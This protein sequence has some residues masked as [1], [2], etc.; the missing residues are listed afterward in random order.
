MVRWGALLLLIFAG[1]W[2]TLG[3]DLSDDGHNIALAWRMS[4]GD[5]PFADE[6]NLRATG[7]LLAV[8]FTWLWTHLF[9][10]TGLVLASRIFF[11]AVAFGV[12]F[13]AYRA[14]RTTLRPVSAA[15]A[16]TAPLMALPY[17]LGQISY[18]TMPVFGLVLGTAAGFAAVVRRDR[19][20]AFIS[21]VAVAVGV[22][23][24]PMIL[25]GGAILLMAVAISSRR[26]D[27]VGSL[28]L[29]SLA[30]LV[31]FGLWL[32]FGISPSLVGDTLRF[33]LDAQALVPPIEQRGS[34]V[35]EVY[36]F[37]L[38]LRKYWPMWGAA[39][40]AALPLLPDRIRAAAI[41]TVPVLAAVP[42]LH[43]MFNGLPGVAFGRLA[44]IY[45][46]VVSLAL[47][48]PVSV[49]AVQ[50]RRRD[51]VV[52]I[53]L[54]LPVA[55]VQVPLIAATT[56]SGP[57]W[58]VHV[59][60]VC[61]LL[62]A[63]AAG[64]CEMVA[65]LVPSTQPLIGVLL[66]VAIG[67]LL[68]FKPFK[69]PFPWLATTRISTGAF[70]GISTDAAG[71]ARINETSAAA[72]RWVEPGEGVLL[73]GLAGDYLLTRGDPVTNIL[74]LGNLGGAS[75]ATLDYFERSGRTPDVVFVNRGLVD[76]LG[77]YDVLASRDPLIAYIIADY[78]VVDPEASVATVFRRN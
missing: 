39:F 56:A 30:V 52:L 66:I 71:A 62:M 10:M 31:P 51:I 43:I 63:L 57:N 77:G 25:I 11:V 5:S 76:Q 44:G 20:W 34:S 32:L 16:V 75:Q 35:L 70:A 28:A 23:S 64:W 60:G 42:S 29:G 41:A 36:T 4:L 19:R 46:T 78:H 14:L 58:G 49:W 48:L 50:R 67:L 65:E 74:W 72:E 27:V 69:D 73:Y 9:G 17:H 26:R 45:V 21:G 38:G 55:L 15:I 2:S 12:G 22:M 24:F 33:T 3:A 7:S 47:L 59:I 1:W 8:P 13:L 37:N 6:M 68:A 53:C 61:S 18:N 54:S 40:V